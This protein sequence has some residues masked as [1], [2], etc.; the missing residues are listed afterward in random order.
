MEVN[1]TEVFSK[2]MFE[3]YW[4]QYAQQLIAGK[5]QMNRGTYQSVA[6]N[7]NVLS[8]RAACLPKAATILGSASSR[9]EAVFEISEIIWGITPEQW[10]EKENAW[11]AQSRQENGLKET[12]GKDK[13]GDVISAEI[14]VRLV[15]TARYIA[16]VDIDNNLTFAEKDL[17]TSQAMLAT[18]LLLSTAVAKGYS[19]HIRVG[20]TSLYKDL[21]D[22]GVVFGNS[23]SKYLPHPQVSL[24]YL[25]SLLHVTRTIPLAYK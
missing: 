4:A 5:V 25:F 23:G 20:D 6:C 22:N 21:R 16:W 19:R 7:L 2:K 18:N 8:L 10:L 17:A 13:V 14:L 11:L 9:K 3:E 15:A 1:M 24:P 12:D